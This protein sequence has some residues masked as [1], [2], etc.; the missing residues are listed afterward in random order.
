MRKLRNSNKIGPTE[1]W[2][3]PE[4]EKLIGFLWGYVTCPSSQLPA[5]LSCTNF[6]KSSS[7]WPNLVYLTSF[8]VPAWLI[9]FSMPILYDLPKGKSYYTLKILQLKDTHFL[10]PQIL[11]P[12]SFYYLFYSKFPIP[13]NKQNFTAQPTLYLSCFIAP[14]LFYF[15]FVPTNHLKYHVSHI[16]G[17]SLPLL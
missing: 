13:T 1:V 17:I 16:C 5:S 9:G 12:F 2:S 14:F 6:Q 10:L 3:Q 15:I 8:Y 7:D 11:H 4:L